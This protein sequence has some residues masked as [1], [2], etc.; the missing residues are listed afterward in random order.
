[1]KYYDIRITCECRLFETGGLTCFHI[2]GV[3]KHHNTKFVP[4]SLILKRWTRK[5]NSD[6]ICSIGEQKST[7]NILHTLRC[8]AIPTIEKLQV[9]N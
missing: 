6:F 2:F 7:D 8:G 9:S 1:M 3:L 4:E 5:A